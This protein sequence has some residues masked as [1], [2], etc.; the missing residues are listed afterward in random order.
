M[1]ARRVLTRKLAAVAVLLILPVRGSAQQMFTCA[2]PVLATSSVLNLGLTGLSLISGSPQT[3]ATAQSICELVTEKG[4]RTLSLY[5]HCPNYACQAGLEFT[6]IGV[7]ASV[8]NNLRSK[9]VSKRGSS[10]FGF[11]ART[12]VKSVSP[13]RQNLEGWHRVE[14][15]FFGAV[16]PLPVHRLWVARLDGPLAWQQ[17]YGVRFHTTKWT[18]NRRTVNLTAIVPTPLGNAAITLGNTDSTITSRRIPAS[19]DAFYQAMQKNELG[20][21]GDWDWYYSPSTYWNSLD[22]L[23][24]WSLEFASP[25]VGKNLGFAEA[26]LRGVVRG[27]LEGTFH[28]QEGQDSSAIQDASLPPH[29]YRRLGQLTTADMEQ[30]SSGL[31]AGVRLTIRAPWHEW[32]EEWPLAQFGTTAPPSWSGTRITGA[33]ERLWGDKEAG[34][35][36]FT[37]CTSTPVATFPEWIRLTVGSPVPPPDDDANPDIP[38]FATKVGQTVSDSF[39]VCPI[40]PVSSA[41]LLALDRIRTTYRRELIAN[42]ATAKRNACASLTTWYRARYGV[43]RRAK[44]AIG[45]ILE[46]PRGRTECDIFG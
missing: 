12:G 42:P 46:Y 7:I 39:V 28:H 41:D 45:P 18:W 37:K 10:W 40:A 8:E 6:G 30:G 11:Q 27:V 25:P 9:L 4:P 29:I 3:Y 17:T 32:R 21:K 22:L 34:G 44:G 15:L 31:S 13:N 38:A 36:D 19:R 35:Y 43:C 1:T 16:L 5:T 33:F 23:T 14:L 24:S 2:D 26:T 20:D